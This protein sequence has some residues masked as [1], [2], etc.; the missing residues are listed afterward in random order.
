MNPIMKAMVSAFLAAPSTKDALHEFANAQVDGAL[1]AEAD[2][3][4]GGNAFVA[5]LAKE[6]KDPKVQAELNNL[7]D[8]ELDQLIATVAA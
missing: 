2:K 3:L 5:L 4:A 7:L 8:A 1:N 6:L